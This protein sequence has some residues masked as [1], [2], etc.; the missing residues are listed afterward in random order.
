MTR[1]LAAIV[2]VAVCVVLLAG[3]GPT[4]TVTVTLPGHAE[5]RL[6][7]CP[8]AT[9]GSRVVAAEASRATFRVSVWQLADGGRTR[10][11]RLRAIG[12]AATIGRVRA[13]SCVGLVLANDGAT[14]IRAL[15]VQL[16][17]GE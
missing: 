13:G 6:T 12:D 8:Q 16:T 11:G 2:A 14:G 4:R 10:I 15:T 3:C 9:G 5:T 7:H 17:S 1:R